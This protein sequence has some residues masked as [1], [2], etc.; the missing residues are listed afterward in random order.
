M[1]LLLV[2]LGTVNALLCCTRQVG[3]QAKF[4]EAVDARYVAPDPRAYWSQLTVWF[5][6]CHDDYTLCCM[7]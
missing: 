3:M 6:A 7:A 5:H 4:R 2:A 1:S